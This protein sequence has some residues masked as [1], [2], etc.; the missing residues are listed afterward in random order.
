LIL[1]RQHRGQQI[2][3][4]RKSIVAKLRWARQV[5]PAEYSNRTQGYLDLRER[6]VGLAAEGRPYP[7]A[8][9]VLVQEKIMH[10][11]HRAVAHSKRGTAKLGRV[12]SEA[13]T[14]RYARFSNSWVSVVEDL[15][16]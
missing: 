2:G 10:L 11:S 5:G 3:A 8:N 6:L 9:L 7:T 16:F 12:F 15:Y 1:Y 14:G 4:L 13:I